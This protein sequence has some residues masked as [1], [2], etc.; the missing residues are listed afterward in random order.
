MTQADDTAPWQE[1]LSGWMDGEEASRTEHR[2][3]TRD[4]AQT[5]RLWQD[6]HVIGDVLRS[7]DLAIIPSENFHARLSAALA[8]E[9]RL[10]AR[11]TPAALW[12]TTW[13]KI[14][15]T[16]QQHLAPDGSFKLNTPWRWSGA[17]ALAAA[18]IWLMVSPSQ[19]NDADSMLASAAEPGGLGSN[20]YIQTHRQFAGN[21]PVVRVSLDMEGQG[22]R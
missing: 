20:P 8:R 18:V 10:Q 11:S 9:T 17:V 4:T 2:T 13:K 1:Q 5:Q 22:S 16:W 15:Q 3:T 14:Q 6:W 12:Q 7:D 21:H 19:H